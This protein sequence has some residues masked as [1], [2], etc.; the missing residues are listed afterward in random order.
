M[1]MRLPDKPLFCISL[2]L[3]CSLWLAGC[4]GTGEFAKSRDT[5]PVFLDKNM[6]VQEA[7]GS[8][9]VGTSTKAAVRAALGA[10][11]VVKFDSGYE[12]WVYRGTDGKATATGAEFVIL[13]APSGVVKKTR[14]RSP[15]DGPVE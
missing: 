15:S 8:I 13:F 6:S 12:V 5:K 11:T 3:A 1:M 9:T 2:A 10:A 7:Q 14:I 4:V